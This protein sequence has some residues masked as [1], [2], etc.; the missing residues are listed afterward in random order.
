MVVKSNTGEEILID[1]EDYEK[2]IKYK[3]YCY[4]SKYPMT[5]KGISIH[6]LIIDCTDDKVVDHING[7]SLDNRKSNLRVCFH[8][9]NIRNQ[10]KHNRKIKCSSNYKG[11]CWDSKNNKWEAYITF[12]Y[13]KIK[14]GRHLKEKD[15]AEAYNDAA[16]KY[17]GEF[18]RLNKV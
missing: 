11:V 8:K 6:R 14:L 2:I 16:I 3:W 17:F 9:E 12:N 15:A 10:K 4:N 7:N 1:D 18:A 13:K 5:S